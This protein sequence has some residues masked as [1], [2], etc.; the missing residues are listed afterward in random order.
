MTTTIIAPA[1]AGKT[2]AG[3]A[4]YRAEFKGP[5]LAGALVLA[6]GFGG[7]GTWAVT[8]P[9][10]TGVTAGATVVVDSHRKSIQHLEGGVVAAILVREG[11]TVAA[12]QPLVKLDPTQLEAQIK[13]LQGRL[14]LALM[15][16]ARLSAERAGRERIAVP[17]E[18]ARRA[19]AEPEAADV[20]AGQQ[21]LFEAR[22]QAL[23]SQ[24]EVLQNR[25]AQSRT[26]IAGLEQQAAA[27]D[28][29]IA[30]I[31]RE[32]AGKSELN[33]KG[34]TSSVQ[35]MAVE[36]ELARLEGQRGEATAQI[37]Q[38]EQAMNEARLQILTM[39]TKFREDVEA[40]MREAE[41]QAFDLTERLGA[42]KDMRARLVIAAPV[43]GEVVDM[44]VHTVGGVVAPGSRILDIVPQD[45]ALVVEAQ[46]PTVDIDDVAVGMPA[47]VHFSAFDRSVVPTVKATV[48]GVS[49]DRLVNDRT[50]AAYYK[51]RVKVDDPAAKAL[52]GL[53]LL[54]GMP[55]EVMIN[56]GDRTLF[57]YFWIP[58]Q[59][60]LKHAL[61]Q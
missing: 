53:R 50:G 48:A 4:P 6:L 9:L 51:V 25:I 59:Q 1:A 57:D 16:K 55:A 23:V 40:Q 45:D 42:V 29:Q 19:Q 44:T 15:Q 58:F 49:A 14:D 36:R 28:A 20:V 35:L 41:A 60:L 38:V 32:I 22:R 43:A 18:L 37:A 21:Q 61:R 46:V 31:K 7:F 34:Y 26:Q 56:K 24:V 27:T 2:T 30:L 47:E 17:V 3:D 5:I 52:D 13:M 8:A 10:A 54:P 11:D 39:Q 33:A 12:G